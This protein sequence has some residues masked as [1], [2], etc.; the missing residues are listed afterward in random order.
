MLTDLDRIPNENNIELKYIYETIR[1]ER[2][3]LKQSKAPSKYTALKTRLYLDPQL[4]QT[5]RQISKNDQFIRLDYLKMRQ[6]F[7]LLLISIFKE[8]NESQHYLSKY[9][10]PFGTLFFP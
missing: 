4:S 1:H 2:L 7:A 5:L 3:L 10:K 8:K 9:D 6:T